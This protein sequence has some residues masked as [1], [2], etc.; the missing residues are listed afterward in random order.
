MHE[1]QKHDLFDNDN[2]CN[3]RRCCKRLMLQHRVQERLAAVIKAEGESEAARLISE[4]TKA[5]GSG[6]IEL[7]RVEAAKE[8]AGTL[9]KGRNVVY[10]PSTGNML[11]NL[12]V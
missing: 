8:I 4:A 3:V 5:Y 6:M 7:R 1:C 2:L 11:L 9:S 10:L 12:Q